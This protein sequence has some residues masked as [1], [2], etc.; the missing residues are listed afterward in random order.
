MDFHDFVQRWFTL[1]PEGSAPAHPE[2]AEPGAAE[3]ASGLSG[4][5]LAQ[6]EY[7]ASMRGIRSRAKDAAGGKGPVA[8]RSAATEL[9]RKLGLKRGK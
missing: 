1:Q 6:R 8:E 3:G 4:K 9:R 7:A 2:P 5:Q